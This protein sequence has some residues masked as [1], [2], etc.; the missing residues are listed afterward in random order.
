[1]KAGLASKLVDWLARLQRKPSPPSPPTKTQYAPRP[2]G[3]GV[4]W[5]FPEAE[6]NEAIRAAK[7]TLPVF[8]AWHE[9]RSDDP[10]DCALKVEF[11]TGARGSEHVWFIDILRTGP[12]VTG[13]VASDVVDVHKRG[14]S[15]VQF[16]ETTARNDGFSVAHFT[17]MS[18]A[19]GRGGTFS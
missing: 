8:W 16:L 5:D 19:C 18:R 11:P 3:K 4:V 17:L 2:A 9:T 13:L 15:M 7:E 10:D 1:M 14:G 6:M 12:V